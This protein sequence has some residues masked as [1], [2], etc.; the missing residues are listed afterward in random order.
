MYDLSQGDGTGSGDGAGGV[1]GVGGNGGGEGAAGGLGGAESQG[2]A[3]A[4][5]RGAAEGPGAEEAAAAGAAGAAGAWA[6]A[7]GA[8]V[9]LLGLVKKPE[10]NGCAGGVAAFVEASGRF[11]V[12]V[13]GGL[14]VGLAAVILASVVGALALACTGTRRLGW[15]C[16]STAPVVLGALEIFHAL[17]LTE[18]VAVLH[19]RDCATLT[20]A[21]VLH[22][23]THSGSARSLKYRSVRSEGA[24]F[25]AVTL[26]G[27]LQF[28]FGS[29]LY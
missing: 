14:A 1:G 12:V 16:A 29:A 5:A 21:P 24:R 23:C 28:T 25:T 18:A 22:I 7:V 27:R 2:A 6:F 3:G 4:G 15:A 26:K 17:R 13:D 9:E 11:S 19:C 20:A 8:R 10:L